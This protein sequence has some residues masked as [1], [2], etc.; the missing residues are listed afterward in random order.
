MISPKYIVLAVEKASTPE[1]REALTRIEAAAAELAVR[2]RDL[3]EMIAAGKIRR[4]EAPV[5]LS[6]D[7]RAML[8]GMGDDMAASEREQLVLLKDVATAAEVIEI[9]SFSFTI[10]CVP[11][12]WSAMLPESHPDDRPA[13]EDIIGRQRALRAAMREYLE[14]FGPS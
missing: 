12:D 11:Q 13:L 4:H 10:P 14:R 2:E 6:R 5:K 1:E 3:P 8:A 7:Q 9:L